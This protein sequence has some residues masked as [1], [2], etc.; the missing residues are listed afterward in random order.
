[1]VFARLEPKHQ[2]PKLEIV[3]ADE[4]DL[5]EVHEYLKRGRKASMKIHTWNNYIALKMLQYFCFEFVAKETDLTPL[6]P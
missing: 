5:S 1:M 4:K 3:V 6:S 2:L